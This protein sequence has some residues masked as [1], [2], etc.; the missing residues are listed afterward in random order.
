MQGLPQAGHRCVTMQSALPSMACA[1]RPLCQLR[2]GAY[3]S[4]VG[5][6][7][8]WRFALQCTA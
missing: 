1:R 2:H 3:L 5:M 8:D 4:C 7:S 6:V